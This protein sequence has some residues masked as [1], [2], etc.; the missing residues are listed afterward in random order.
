MILTKV[1]LNPFGGISSREIEFKP[2]LNVVEGPNE[3][4]KSTVFW[5][6]QRA[7]FTPSK[8][9]KKDF[10]S[11]I[12]RFLPIGGGDTIHVELD[13]KH[14]GQEYKLARTWGASQSSELM[15]PN[16]SK[17]TDD[18][19]ISEHIKAILPAN[20]GTFKSV[21]MTYQ[22][23]LEKT[24]DDLKSHP[25][26]V[27]TL[28]D[29]LRR[30]VMETDGVSV[31]EFRGRI[32]SLYNEYFRRW[33]RD[34]N[35]PEGGR[36]INKPWKKGAGVIVNK[37][38]E[39]EAIREAFEKARRYEEELDR[40][41]QEIS[42]A[43]KLV[44]EKEAFIKVNK[45][46]VEDIRKRRVL[47][48]EL[49]A[50]EGEIN[51][52]KKVNSA[53]PVLK[54]QIKAIKKDIPVLEKKEKELI[55]EESQAELMENNKVLLEKFR[56]V[57]EKK[58]ALD[59]AKERLKKARKLTSADL[60]AIRTVKTE[61]DKIKTGIEAGKLAINFKTK[62][63]ISL[64]I[65]KDFEEEVLKEIKTGNYL[66]MEAGGRI[67]LEH[68]DW[69]L[70]VTSGEGDFAVIRKKH[71]ETEVKLAELLNKYS[72]ESL[73]HAEEVC[74]EYEKHLK[75][76]ERADE[77]FKDELGEDSY[78]GLSEQVKKLGEIKE[79]RS[80]ATIAKELANVR[81][82]LQAKKD[83]LKEK[84]EKL[85]EFLSKYES[86]DKLILQLADVMG[87]EREIN[88]K[89]ASLTPLPEG[90]EDAEIFIKEYEE[91]EKELDD[92]KERKKKL[93]IKR[94]EL[95]APEESSEELE[96]QLK[97]AEETFHAVLKKGETIARIKDMTEK[98]LEEMDSNTYEGLEKDLEKY[99]A[100]IT[101]N[102]YSNVEM[103]EGFPLGFVRDDGA[104]VLYELLSHGT[105]DIL[106]LALRL[107]MANYFLNDADGF[108]A[109]DDPL[110]N[111]DPRRQQ[112]AVEILK[113][114]ASQKQ[115]LIFTC[116]PGHGDLLG[117]HLIRL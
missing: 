6:I 95:V 77:N 20:E 59:K 105:K 101:E 81:N 15:M 45:K 70:E 52:I 46:I 61:L 73:K 68:Q 62:R 98:I 1:R 55:N 96:S 28:G 89:L 69:V 3:A 49:K 110:V 103:E 24:L 36:G 16:G 72:V 12:N 38:Y 78:E 58:E 4:G 109:M 108:I 26:T 117:G 56:R 76:V 35:H 79:T 48:A 39:K 107:S 51:E 9:H 104:V 30:V 87:K 8:L 43:A 31:S 33:D 29:L 5:A 74:R 86:K 100:T 82:A 57:N 99:V 18:N 91:I 97:D 37:Y 17:I 19:K 22:S 75:D 11:E 71:E 113:D 67:I 50:I 106:G 54:A 83:A 13:F 40:L 66:R 60:D 44:S 102:R 10:E 94:A 111:L 65:Q 85:Q 7:L 53:W 90:I 21:L 114:Y 92:E 14:N 42:E 80:L 88:K 27:H 116:H 93:E 47:S 41:N 112:K 32:Q 64:K 34:R 63:D 23:G 25:E 84:E 115:L 2:G